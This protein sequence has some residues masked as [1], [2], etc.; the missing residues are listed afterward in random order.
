[1][2]PLFLLSYISQGAWH[3][4]LLLSQIDGAAYQRGG[5]S[6]LQIHTLHKHVFHINGLALQPSHTHH[7]GL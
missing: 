4:V 3:V 5:L 6:T 1:M 7:F 2:S